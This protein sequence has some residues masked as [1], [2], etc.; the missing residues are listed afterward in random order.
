MTALKVL[1]LSFILSSCSPAVVITKVEK[2]FP[3]K[4][5]LRDCGS[6]GFS[7]EAAVYSDLVPYI[8]TLQSALDL[9]NND[10][11]ALR[12]WAILED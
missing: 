9:C 11:R 10:K 8:K 3:E 12:N 7:K 5:Y 2:Q 6:P 4:K 1:S